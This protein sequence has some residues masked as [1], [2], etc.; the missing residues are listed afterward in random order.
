MVELLT[1]QDL[2]ARLTPIRADLALLKWMV[3]VTLAGV[4]VL[5]V[6]AFF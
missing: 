4:V 5:V 3:G 2:R 6:K 1:K